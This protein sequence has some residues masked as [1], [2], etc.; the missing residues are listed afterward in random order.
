MNLKIKKKLLSGYFLNLIFLWKFAPEYVYVFLVSFYVFL[1]LFLTK[2]IYPKHPLCTFNSNQF[3]SSPSF[4]FQNW[5]SIFILCSS[6]SSFI[7]YALLWS[8]AE[9]SIL[10]LSSSCN[11][12]FTPLRWLYIVTNFH[13]CF[14]LSYILCCCSLSHIRYLS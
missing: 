6:G 8:N 13:C 5:F 4:S 12:N 7:Y 1:L 3:L 2:W 10:I 11:T 9:L 14:T